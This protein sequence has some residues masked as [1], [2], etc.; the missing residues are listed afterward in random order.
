TTGNY[1][2][3]TT[4]GTAVVRV[5]DGGGQYADAI[6]TINN[7][8]QISPVNQSL[9]VNATQTF[10]TTG[11]VSPIQYSLVSGVGSVDA[12][13][14]LYTAPA[15]S[16]T[17]VVRAKDSLGNISDANV[18]VFSSLGISP[19]TPTVS[20]NTNL[21]FSAA[22]GGTPY[23]YSIVSGGGSINP[24]TGDFTAPATPSTTVVRVTDSLSHTADATVT[25]VNLS[26]TISTISNQSVKSD[27]SVVVNYTINDSDSTLDCSTSVT[28]VSSVTGTLPNAD[29]VKGGTAPNCTLTISPSLNVAGS[30]NITVTVSD[31]N[32]SNNTSFSLSV[33]N[34]MSVAVTP[35]TLNLAVSGTSQLTAVANYSDLT[36]STVTT[37]SLASWS[38]SA[39]GVASVNNTTSKGLVTGA[40]AG[41]A[42]VSVSYKGVTSNNS[43]VTV[44]S[45]NSVT[46]SSGSVSGGI[47]SQAFVSASAQSSSSAFDITSTAVWS[48]S[49]SSVATVSNGVISF[50]SAGTA[51]ITVTYAGLTANVSVTVASKTLTSVAVTVNGGGT[52]LSLNGTK[53]LTATATY[54]DSSTADVTS[55]ASWSS[56][57]TAVLTVSNSI[58]HIGRVT[59]VAGG[60]STVT[61]TVGAISGNILLTVNAVTLSSIAVTPADSLVA[62]G[63]NYSLHATGTY[64]DS[65]TADITDLVTW[66][67]SNTAAATISNTAGS[68]GVATTPSFAGYKTTTI[69]ATLNAV[70]GTTPFGVN[71]AAISSILVTPTVSIT[72]GS[73]YQLK[74][75]ANLSD[76]GV[77]D[78]T[79]FS[80]W[81]SGSTSNVTVS[82][83]QGSQGLVTGVANG[84]SSV[85]AQ[86]GGVSGTNTVTVAGSS[87]L[88]EIGVGLTGTYYT[89]TGTSPPAAPF[90]LANEK[91]QRIDAT[92][93]FAW[94]AGNA[95]MG[96]GDQFAARWTGFYKA[97]SATN[98]FCTY[99]DD[100]IRVWVN[101]VQ[102]INNWTDH[103]PAWNCSASVA[104]TAG[105][106]YAV[107]IE[108]YENA[109]GA[110]AHLT[111][112]SI[113]AADAQNTA[114][115]FIPQTDLFPF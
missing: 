48:T 8:L 9:N 96:V 81:S 88:T 25:I 22:G 76:G 32:S 5:I 16:G 23:V 74:S 90:V 78:L 45:V 86:F 110:E 42:N 70:S 36:Q 59:G 79:N 62:S 93:N 68:K 101:G 50:V 49:N 72:A 83:S 107:I 41:S 26:P 52:S 10:T 66:S 71:G 7:A 80:I 115:R 69:T 89:W 4:S 11:G 109:G 14:G 111:R 6:I 1:T 97:T 27:S 73:N 54:S 100:G 61:A 31:G 28:A 29:I 58:P 47:G 38:S 3:P 2:A 85:M 67:S 46:V 104:L 21:T 106:K 84:T 57:N 75:Y 99:S 95:P 91:G 12:A 108:F 40:S 18:S 98:F 15:T 60:T 33:I 112:S 92:P 43:A 63:G 82:N 56:S 19:A 103:S 94:G 30:T 53:D 64:S 13:T 55:A 105:T 77:V 39:S 114:T 51:T 17:A 20:I 35:N 87:S 102:I 44:I 65:S 34:V 113:S 37:S 24:S